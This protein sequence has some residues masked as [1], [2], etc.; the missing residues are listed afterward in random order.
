MN[1]PVSPRRLTSRRGA[2]DMA[3]VIAVRDGEVN[4]QARW[5]S[6]PAGRQA[7]GPAGLRVDFRL[8]R[9][10]NPVSP[11]RLTS[12]RGAG[13][14]AQVIAVRDGEVNPQAR[15]RSRPAGR[16]ASGPAGLHERVE[17]RISWD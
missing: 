10:N 2:G 5:R 4:P 3:Q 6:R 11:R 8:A 16:Q 15:W 9:M 17:A 7:S 1:N 13:D 14:M 12:R